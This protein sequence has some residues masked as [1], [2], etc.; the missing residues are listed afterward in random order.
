M[1]SKIIAF[2]L[3]IIMAVAG[4][5]L[6][7]SIV[8]FVVVEL[9]NVSNKVQL[10]DAQ[11]YRIL[12]LG[13]STTYRQYPLA[14]QKLLSQRFPATSF[15]V[16]D[17]GMPGS[18]S[19]YIVSIFEDSICTYHPQLV[20]V[21][22][23]NNDRSEECFIKRPVV[24]TILDT[25][26]LRRLYAF[27]RREIIFMLRS[28]KS[29]LSPPSLPFEINLSLGRTPAMQ[30]SS[31]MELWMRQ[32]VAAFNNG[33]LK[34]AEKYFLKAYEM[35]YS[36]IN[37]NIFALLGQIYMGQNNTRKAE[38]VYQRAVFLNPRN[39]KAYAHLAEFYLSCGNTSKAVEIFEKG[40]VAEPDN[41]YAY[42]PLFKIYRDLHH[43]KKIDVLFR[44]ASSRFTLNDRF[45][46]ALAIQCMELKQYTAAGVYF[47]MAHELQRNYFKN[48]TMRN[49]KRMISIASKNNIPLVLMQYPLRNADT[50]TSLKSEY[51]NIYI[52]DNSKN[53]LNAL[54]CAPYNALF[55]DQFAGDFGHCTT[56][57]NNLV[58]ENIIK[59]IFSRQ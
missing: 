20:I 15:S 51:H 19:N 39:S 31:Q 43:D 57:G 55:L 2:V 23:G 24:E 38:Q 59:T 3:G 14:L 52:V 5:E 10:R 16:I 26:K 37:L 29:R 44:Y 21:M 25:V 41:F 56:R 48:V 8:G 35:N 13:D 45:Y 9:Q 11:A 54:R 32:G 42:V 58:A 27:V 17:K 12:C 30:S 18:D 7:L 40:V 34:T 6:L 53:F 49:L 33:D 1:K 28:S 4:L 36:D 46:G 22:T 50:F 47:D